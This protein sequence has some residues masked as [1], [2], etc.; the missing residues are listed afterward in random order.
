MRVGNFWSEGGR[1]VNEGKSEG[2]PGSSLGWAKA[3]QGMSKV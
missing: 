1:G 2:R 3:V